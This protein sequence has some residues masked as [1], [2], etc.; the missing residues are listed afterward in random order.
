MEAAVVTVSTGV[1]KPLLSKLFKLLL[2]EHG[3]LKGVRHD[4]KFIGD[5]LRSMKAALEVLADEE[6][7]EP[8][9]RIW[10][11][12]VRELSYD[13][14][15]CI[16][17]FVAHVDHE[18][19]GRTT[20]KKFVDMLKKP[21]HRHQTAS[22]IVK[23]KARATQAS[24]RHKRYN[25]IRPT[26]CISS[27]SIDPRLPAL[28][29]EVDEL[30]GIDGPKDDIIDW[31][32]WEATSTQ[33]QVLSIVGSGGLG[34]TTLA[35][36]VYHAMESHFSCAAF[37]S[38]SRNPDM[39]KTLRD[40][41]GGVGFSDYTLDD[42]VQQLI[43][44]LRQYLKDERYFVVIDDVWSA[45]AWET[46]RLV[47]L[48]NNHGSRIITTTRNTE[49]A[50]CCS[51]GGG[52]VYRME[53]LT[54]DDSKRLFFR[55]AFGPEDLCYP[56]LEKVSN[57]ILRK[58]SGL[59]LAIITV[60]SLL[61]DQHAED[62]WKRVLA[63]IGSALANDS[64]ADKMTKI[65]SLSYFDLPHHLRA[66]LLYLSIFPEDSAIWKQ[67]LIHKW[68]AEGFIHEKQGRS[69][70]EIG[71]TYF[72]EL[73]NR[74][75]IQPVGATFSQVESCQVHDIILDFIT[76]KA[77]EEN[78]VTKFSD[79]EDGH[80]SC[81]RVR[82]LL[83]G[84]N[85]NEKVAISAPILSHVRSLIIYAHAPQVS[86]LIFPV[87]RVLD[88]G[89]CWWLEDHHVAN[90][91]KLLLLKYLCLANVTLLPKKI[92]ELQYLETLGIANTRILE[93]PL[94]VTSLQRLASLN[95][96]Y[97]ISFPDGMIGKMQSLEDIETLGVHS[98]EQGKSLQEFSQLTKMR[99]LK[100]QL[101]M[102]ELW[103]GTGQIEDLHGYLGTLVSSCNLRHLNISKLSSDVLA[104]KTYFPLSLESWCPTTPCSLQELHITYCYIDKVPN[105]MSL[106]RNLR[107]LEIYVVSVRPEDVR[108]LGSIPTLL[109]LKLKTFNGTD[110][111]I[112][113]H[114]FSNLKYFHLELL[115]CGTSLEFEEGSMPR[116]E[117]LELEFR[118]HQM[119]CLNGSLNFGI[120][121][122]SALRKVEV[123]IFGNFGNKDNAMAGLECC[124]GKSIGI[125]IEADIEML[126]NCSSFLLQYGNVAYGNVAC[127]HYTKMVSSLLESVALVT[128]VHPLNF[129]LATLFLSSMP[130][131]F[132]QPLLKYH[133]RSSH[134][135]GHWKLAIHVPEP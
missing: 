78:F 7:L 40:I 113:I 133:Q 85:S 92:G 55:R 59:P 131:N 16:D 110:G 94:A 126:P 72:N 31:F 73:I 54:F 3:K 98:Y 96:H 57:E 118:V 17:V 115:Y 68:I 81:Y 82:R 8:A 64:G 63:A 97:H 112:L 119:D 52:H 127:E 25:I 4:A 134:G 46:I 36:Q 27:C 39:R 15:D 32:Q 37:V 89:K 79:V 14:E 9:M 129:L 58:C 11:D 109:I 35:N 87:L 117:H 26:P 80:N 13:M 114:G 125:L 123:C 107:E 1:M 24:E 99:R 60:S 90:I 42:H 43:S 69:R 132:G 38:V 100:V 91:E 12:D 62:E 2:E 121:H 20:L 23:L 28:Y 22:E 56:H 108:I 10:R 33:P 18:P 51:S 47:L 130:Q 30:V 77:A 21:K 48:N 49:V 45:D 34:K 5:E 86:L 53:P 19:D 29:A 116:L 71:E 88:L 41:A 44:K 67:R 105:W 104:V 65:L 76:C 102:F 6:Q 95:V 106:L 135:Q 83:V 128:S 61:A 124:F 66:C 103:E 70:Y 122:L 84:N 93:M 111:R 101:G 75:L 50:S 74:S 120:Q